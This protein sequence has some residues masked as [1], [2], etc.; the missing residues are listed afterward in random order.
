VS[1]SLYGKLKEK[2]IS[3]YRHFKNHGRINEI[4]KKKKWY[5]QVTMDDDIEGFVSGEA[6]SKNESTKEEG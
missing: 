5:D 4:Y 6:K 1:E 2:S 3:K